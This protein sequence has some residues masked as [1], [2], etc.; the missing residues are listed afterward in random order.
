[1]SLSKI[2]DMQLIPT[3]KVLKLI[4]QALAQ[5][6]PFSLVRV[7]DG[8][9]IV[10][11]QNIFLSLNEVMNSY[12]V[13]QSKTGRGK[14]ITLPNLRLRNQMIDS[15]RKASIVGICRNFND[16]VSVRGKYKRELTNKIFD[17]FHLKPPRLCYVFINRQMVSRRLF[18]ELIHQYRTILISKWAEEYAQKIRSEYEPSSLCPNIVG[19]INFSHYDQLPE[20][21]KKV[22]QYKFDLALISTGVNAVVLAPKIAE[23]YGKV[24]IDFGK[25]MMYTVKNC[26]RVNPWKPELPLEPSEL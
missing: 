9:N 17:Y 10:L 15:I 16:E 22:G 14:G 3:E 4:R 1:M 19:C 11:S 26:K 24:A 8:E 6:L 13:K 2:T 7:G 5:K 20:T 12:W 21:I 18:W 23:K 25:T